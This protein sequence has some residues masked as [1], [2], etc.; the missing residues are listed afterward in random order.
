MKCPVMFAFVRLCS[1]SRQ[2]PPACLHACLQA[3]F[4]LCLPIDMNQSIKLERHGHAALVP[5]Q[6][7]VLS[8]G[9]DAGLKAFLQDSVCSF[10]ALVQSGA[11]D[12]MDVTVFTKGERSAVGRIMPPG[13]IVILVGTLPDSVTTDQIFVNVMNGTAS[14][15][16]QRVQVGSR[17]TE[18]TECTEFTGVQV[19]R[20]Y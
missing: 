18:F 5:K 10:D 4:P 11:L 15:L 19:Y 6:N 9:Y 3:S 1:Q 14:R 12:G 13:E 17:H 2:C 8:H 7:S 16:M 20:M